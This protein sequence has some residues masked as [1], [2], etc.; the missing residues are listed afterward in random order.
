[1]NKPPFRILS[2][3]L[4]AVLSIASAHK[5]DA[6]PNDSQPIYSQ[7]SPNRDGVGKVYMGREISFVMGHRGI[8]WLERPERRREERTDLV[9][10][11]MQLESDS[12]VVD[13][14]AGSGYF[15]F[16]IGP[17]VSQGRVLA[18][19]IQQKCSRSSNVES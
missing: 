15:S 2:S 17:S 5:A 7:K 19:D 3:L 9:I 13:L 12:V 14:G 18:V 8:D 16:R 1:M 6:L 4:L 11:G 10:R